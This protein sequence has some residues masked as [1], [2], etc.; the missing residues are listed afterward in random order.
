MKVGQPD[1]EAGFEA[2]LKQH[3]LTG[4]V[5]QHKFHP[6][7]KWAFDFAWPAP[8]KVAVELD[9]GI[10]FQKFDK[11]G[12][13]IQQGGHSTPKGIIGDMD[14]LNHAASLNW[15]VLRFSNVHLK[16]QPVQCI[17]LLKQTLGCPLSSE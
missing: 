16:T 15:L 7:R 3:G 6:K 1:L 13:P 8:L 14:K 10:K 9:G 17:E 11:H 4:Y 12:L 5:R 2:L